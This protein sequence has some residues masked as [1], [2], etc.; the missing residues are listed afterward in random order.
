[1]SGGSDPVAV[2]RQE[3]QDLLV[4]LEDALLDLEGTPGDSELIGQAF[5]ALHTIKGSGA[6]FGFEDVA[7]FTHHVENAFE[8]VRDGRLAISSAL[9]RIALR[10]KDRMRQM[11]ENPGTACAEDGDAILAELTALVGAAPASVAKP[12]GDRGDGATA[13]VA[14]NVWRIRFRLPADSLGMGTN[15]LLMLQELA[16]MGTVVVIADTSQVPPIEEMDPE[17]NYLG[18]EVI[19]STSAPKRAIEDV[20]M[21]VLDDC[22]L[23]VDPME[24]EAA[25]MAPTDPVVERTAPE[26]SAPPSSQPKSPCEPAKPGGQKQGAAIVKVQAERIDALMDQVGEL[27]IAQSRLKRISELLDDTTLRTV[28]EEIERL[29]AG[30]RDTTM[31]IRMVPVGSLFNRFRRV[32]HDLSNELGKDVNLE[33]SGEETEMDKTVIESLGDPLVHLIRNALDHGI[34]NAAERVA[35]GKPAQGRV[36][37]TATHMGAEVLIAVA[38][39]GRGLNAQRIRAKAVE[40]GL[41]AADAEIS[42]QDLYRFIFHPGFSTAAAV[43][44]VS[45]R[46]VGM[47]VVKRTIESLRGNID[48]ESTPGVGTRITLRLPLTLAIIDGLLVQVGD[49]RYIIPLSAVEECVEMSGEDSLRESGRDFLDLRGQL[50]PFL[51]L[52]DLFNVRA[53]PPPYPKIVIAGTGG[54]KV[55]LVVDHLLGSHQTVIKSLSRLHADVEMFSGAT[56]L[57]DGGVALILDIPHLIRFSQNR[58]QMARAS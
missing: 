45:G 57:G 9:I 54:Q 13:A 3:A 31:G 23:S 49:A 44:S 42:D 22:G 7:A 47:D 6:M 10:A 38:D 37:L 52:R 18:W 35:A 46:G 28:A 24:P 21:F 1:M 56:I 12:H 15:P 30:L 20:F 40:R 11:I 27:V 16:D 2:F 34:G 25:I 48:V 5:R 26:V 8:R 41:L 58:E 51:R 36:S 32:V 17:V 50:V 4:Q 29:S 53:E 43:T 14:P 55:G 33:M 19:L 39:D